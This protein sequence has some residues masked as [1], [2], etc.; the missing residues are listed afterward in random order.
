MCDEDSVNSF[1]AKVALQP[2]T[3]CMVTVYSTESKGVLFKEKK[4]FRILEKHRL[5]LCNIFAEGRFENDA[6]DGTDISP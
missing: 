1:P 5:F 2:L 6:T 3:A 4:M